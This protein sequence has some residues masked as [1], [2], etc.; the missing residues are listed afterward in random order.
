[1]HLD[2]QHWEAIPLNRD[3]LNLIFSEPISLDQAAE[4]LKGAIEPQT[5]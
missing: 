2:H 3:A 5:P 1:M 4:F